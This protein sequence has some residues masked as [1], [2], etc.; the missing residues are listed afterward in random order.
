MTL[1]FIFRKIAVILLV[2]ICIS[3][4]TAKERLQIVDSTASCTCS[5]LFSYLV[6]KVK[7]NYINYSKKIKGKE[8][9]FEQHTNQIRKQIEEFTRE[10]SILTGGKVD[11]KC[12]DLLANWLGFFNDPHLVMYP[13]VVSTEQNN[14]AIIK[15]FFSYTDTVHFSP[16]A[17]YNYLHKNKQRLHPLE[18]LWVRHYNNSGNIVF[19]IKKE[20]NRFVGFYLSKDTL[21]W[22]PK[23]IC[24]ILKPSKESKNNFSVKYYDDLHRVNYLTAAFRDSI[25]EINRVGALCKLAL[26]NQSDF[27]KIIAQKAIVRKV[28]LETLDKNTIVLTLPSFG[29]LSRITIDS[30]VTK[31]DSLIKNTLHL[32]LDVRG[33]VGGTV[34]AFDKILPI[35][36]TKP[37]YIH[38]GY[39]CANPNTINAF[40]QATQKAI[41][42]KR[43]YAER[44]KTILKQLQDKPGSFVKIAKE[45]TIIFDTVYMYPKYISVLIDELTVSAGELFV[46]KAMQSDKTTIYGK[47][48]NEGIELIDVDADKDFPYKGLKLYMPYT[49]LEPYVEQTNFPTRLKPD[50]EIPYSTKN[51]IDFV[52]K[53][54]Y[55]K[56]LTKP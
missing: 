53:Y 12:Y 11:G 45:R 28:S 21:F 48:T 51:W 7:K 41:E 22:M 35:I 31:Y 24:F 6:P 29:R 54:P 32:I 18:G 26:T 42:E 2:I 8:K 34:L 15:D 3:S 36:Y 14:P 37:I 13:T 52:V 49:K 38:A 30:L 5:Q 47:P 56:P 17:F 27:Q 46:L 40:S 23:Q 33:N 39:I 50:V 1:I 44:Y 4:I 43:S 16:N 9:E 20:K 25:I 55:K 19:G 10:N